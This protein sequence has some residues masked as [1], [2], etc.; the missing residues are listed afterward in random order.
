MRPIDGATY[1]RGST[2]TSVVDVRRR[3]LGTRRPT[4]ARLDGTAI[5]KGDALDTTAMGAHALVVTATDEAGN[6]EVVSLAYSVEPPLTFTITPS[7]GPNGTISPATAQ[8]V[9]SG[10]SQAFTIT[11][12]DRLPRR[13]R[14]GRRRLGGR[15]S[16]SYTFT[17]VTADHTISATLR[18]RHLHD[19]ATAGPNGAISPATPQTVDYGGSRAF[20]IT[21]ATGY[22]VADVLVD[23]VS[24]GAGD[25][26]HVHQRDRRPHDQRHVR[27]RHLHDHARR[28]G[29]DGTISPRGAADR[30][31]RRPPAFTITPAPATT[32]PTC[33]STASR[34][35]RSRAY[36]FTNVTADHT[37]SATFAI[38]M[39]TI[40][41][42]AG[43]HGVISPA[44]PQTVAFGGSLT[45][46]ITAAAGYYVADVTVDG[47]SVGP[48][49]SYSFLA[50]AADHTIGASF[51]FGPQAGL[52]MTFGKTVGHVRWLD[53]PGGQALRRDHRDG[54]GRS[55]RH[56]GADLIG[57]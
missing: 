27:D 49:T 56:A 18:D 29:P 40:T 50:V 25:E 30:R 51:A 33:S 53:A 11:P 21:P 42:T 38:D 52:D 7:A 8:T 9:D 44:T 5:D 55:Q 4:T 26:L 31:L 12:D 20:T 39:F 46:T 14:A 43:L 2:V 37:I 3:P 6:E 48:A 24:V 32:S 54:S 23:G 34:W 1:T 47:A 36:T 15:R 13:R 19:H 35:A 45:F 41:P 22:H 16:P 57:R 28:P 10:G 17:N